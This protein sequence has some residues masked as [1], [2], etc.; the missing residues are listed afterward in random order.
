MK[1]LGKNLSSKYIHTCRIAEAIVDSK[2]GL[3]QNMFYVQL[4]IIIRVIAE[5][6]E[7]EGN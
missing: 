5:T 6:R 1:L 4:I 3:R 2:N 7:E